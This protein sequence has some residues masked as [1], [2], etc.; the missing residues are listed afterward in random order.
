MAD[1]FFDLMEEEVSECINVTT[2]ITM[3]DG[4]EFGENLDIERVLS[5][6]LRMYHYT[7]FYINADGMT[8]SEY[9]EKVI[10]IKEFILEKG[11]YGSYYVKFV[12]EHFFGE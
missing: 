4:E 11:I 5:G 7:D 2:R 6:E 8:E 10:D 3:V 1:R 12:Y 9:S